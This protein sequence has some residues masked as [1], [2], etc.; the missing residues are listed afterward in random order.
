MSRIIALHDRDDARIA[1][2]QGLS[3]IQLV[4]LLSRPRWHLLCDAAMET[5]FLQAGLTRSQMTQAL[6][7]GSFLADGFAVPGQ[8]DKTLVVATLRSELAALGVMQRRGQRAIGLFRTLL[9]RL[10]AHSPIGTGE[11]GQDAPPSRCYAILGQPYSGAELL[12]KALSGLGLREPKAHIGRDQVVFARN[13]QATD[14]DPA[15]WWKLLLRSQ[16]EDGSFA[17]L[18][19]WPAFAEFLAALTPGE[20]QWL[21]RQMAGFSVLRIR[22]SDLLPVAVAMHLAGER[23]GDA[24]AVADIRARWAKL[25]AE[26]GEMDAWLRQLGV[27]PRVID[28]DALCDNPTETARAAARHIGFKVK[29]SGPTST[30][31]TPATPKD[32]EFARLIDLVRHADQN[33]REPAP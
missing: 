32:P 23:Q 18:L 28:H 27:T 20:V 3:G 21:N 6:E 9:P 8:A 10:I 11:A 31:Q 14:F 24:D 1:V 30:A 15:Q 5:H 25:H 13:R 33:A 22:H 12:A 19:L 29:A 17:T 2:L 7:H 4:P 16:T 26:E